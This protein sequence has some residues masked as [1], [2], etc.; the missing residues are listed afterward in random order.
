MSPLPLRR[1][2]CQRWR[3]LKRQ[4]LVRSFPSLIVAI[5]KSIYLRFL[6]QI[7]LPPPLLRTRMMPLLPLL[8]SQSQS[9]SQ[10]QRL[11]R[12]S[13]S[14]PPPPP[15]AQRTSRN[16]NRRSRRTSLPPTTPGWS[17]RQGSSPAHQRSL[18]SNRKSMKRLR[19]KRNIRRRRTRSL[20]PAV[21]LPAPTKRSSMKSMNRRRNTMKRSIMRRNTT[22]RSIMK[23]STMRMIDNVQDSTSRN[24]SCVPPINYPQAPIEKL[25]LWNFFS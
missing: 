22:R 14:P 23:R 9:Q 11:R 1:P 18:N 17:R 4:K 7:L 21:P 8:H 19:T 2:Q 13:M 3:S 6:S 5:F 15:P 16:K 24:Q 10:S 20:L 25:W 12:P